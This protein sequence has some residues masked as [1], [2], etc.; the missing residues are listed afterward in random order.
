MGCETAHAIP[1]LALYCHNNECGM[2]ERRAISGVSAENEAPPRHG[3]LRKRSAVRGIVKA[4]SATLAVL[5]V[6]SAGVAAYAVYDTLNTVKSNAVDISLPGSAEPPPPPS[7]GAIEGG[8]N[9]L[10]VGTDNDA[11]Q[12]LEYGEREATLNDV[13]ILLHVSADHQNAVAVSLPRDLIVPHPVCTDPESGEVFDS[14]SAQPLNDSFERGG[15]GCVVA[16]VAGFTGLDIGYA[17]TVS[18]NG[19]IA[20]SDAVGG[21]PVCLAGPVFDPAAGLDLPQGE[22]VISGST[23]L[24]FLRARKEIGDGSDLSRIS[25]QQS[26]MASLLRTVRGNETLT[27]PVK[28]YGLAQVAAKNMTFSTSL[29]SPE[30]MISLALSLK[31]L[32][33]ENVKF[34]Q[35]PVVDSSD[36]SGK[37]EPAQALAD[38]LMSL[39]INDQP[40]A[41]SSG[42]TGHGV[43]SN[44][45]AVTPPVEAPPVDAPPADPTS[46]TAPG[47]A[48]PPVVE[49]LSGQN[50]AE[51]TCTKAYSD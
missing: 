36:F 12:G 8:F 22:S 32:P 50:A 45:G 44:G 1:G 20:L 27:D 21:V 35:Y 13:N 17:A 38:E 33:L 25:N 11:A 28:L 40:F 10:L 6:S 41:L 24:A 29:A 30:A 3:R 34:V 7:F 9:L 15:L 5:L 18:F 46:T 43:E 39:I 42:S 16:T 2:A 49:G 23:A 51:T 26:F 48:P 4:V 31:D 47:I 14:M 19:V 37:V